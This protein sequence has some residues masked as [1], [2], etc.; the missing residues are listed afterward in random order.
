MKHYV[1]NTLT[2]ATRL[3]IVSITINSVDKKTTG[4]QDKN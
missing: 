3:S 1:V 4:F 2:C